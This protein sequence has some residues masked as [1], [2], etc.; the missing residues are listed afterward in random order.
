MTYSAMVTIIFITRGPVSRTKPVSP[1]G[2]AEHVRP[3]AAYVRMVI[4]TV[5]FRP[6]IDG[7]NA[8][9][10]RPMPHATIVGPSDFRLRYKEIRPVP[11]A[12]SVLPAELGSAVKEYMMPDVTAFI[13]D[14]FQRGPAEHRIGSAVHV[15]VR[16]HVS[17]V[18]RA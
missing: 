1:R 10:L 6:P 3:Y 14:I 12:I 16:G 18:G 15:H 13:E 9:E 11:H 5:S 17:G 8:Q 2:E 4:G 7:R